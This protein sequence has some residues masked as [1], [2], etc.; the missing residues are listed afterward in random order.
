MSQWTEQGLEPRTY[1]SRELSDGGLLGY[2]GPLYSKITRPQS[3]SD[4]KAMLW[5]PVEFP[6]DLWGL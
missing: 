4:F 1:Q 2:T 3:A 5:V 6:F